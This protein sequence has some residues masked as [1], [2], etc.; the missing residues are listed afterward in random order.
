MR[1][2]GRWQRLLTGIPATEGRVEV[3]DDVR[4]AFQREPTRAPVAA[5]AV[6]Q[7]AVCIAGNK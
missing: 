6:A 5:Y 3:G 7:T 4:L 1:T 2:R